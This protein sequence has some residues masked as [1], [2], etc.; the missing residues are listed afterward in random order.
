M[1]SMGRQRRLEMA[2]QGT[3]SAAAFTAENYKFTF[4]NMKANPVQGPDFF[5]GIGKG[6][7]LNI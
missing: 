3:L 6:Q 5:S 4:I 7:I 2:E 1:L